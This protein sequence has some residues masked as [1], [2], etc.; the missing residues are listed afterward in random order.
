MAELQ[1]YLK[2]ENGKGRIKMGLNSVVFEDHGYYIIYIP[3]LN[4]SAYGSSM[5]EAQEMFEVMIDD[6]CENLYSL[7]EAERTAEL[8]KYGWNRNPYFNKRF[9]ISQSFVDK[10]GLLKNFELSE[11]TKVEEKFLMIA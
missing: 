1:E 6:F 4:I 3:S 10:E 11:D 5:M 2:I 7:S 9:E 8:R